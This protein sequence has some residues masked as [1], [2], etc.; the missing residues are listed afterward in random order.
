[1]DVCAWCWKL[2]DDEELVNGVC[3]WCLYKK[4]PSET[5]DGSYQASTMDPQET[6]A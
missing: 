6:G 5:S 2:F 4:R 3:F 1:M